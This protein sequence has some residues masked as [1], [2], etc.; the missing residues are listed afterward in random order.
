MKNLI[1]ND[2]SI[3]I[4]LIRKLN[5]LLIAIL[6]ISYL[7]I[8]KNLLLS[9]LI[10]ICSVIIL[11]DY[12]RHKNEIIAKIFN[13]IF[14]K[15]LRD[16]E[17]NKLC[18]ASYFSIAAIIIFAFCPKIIAINAFLILA[19]SDSFA[20]IIGKKINSK[21]FFEKSLAGSIAFFITGFIAIAITGL[22]FQDNILYYI[23]AAIALYATTIIEAR[24]SLLK[25]DDNLTIPATFSF[26][27][28]ILNSIWIYN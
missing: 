18:G 14:S 1:N 3:K 5:H 21:A 6:P 11:I 27:L 25:L 24:P 20:A 8:A 22:I 26:V 17:K 28:V 2:I 4:E 13:L 12:F 16:H 9:F 10:P 7:F 15:I 19:I 23:F